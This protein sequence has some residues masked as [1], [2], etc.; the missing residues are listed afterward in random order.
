[1]SDHRQQR[2]YQQ[3]DQLVKRL[4]PNSN[5]AQGYIRAFWVGGVI[6]V[7]GQLISMAGESWFHMTEASAAMLTSI[8]LIFLGTTLT[9]IGVYD[10]IGRYAGAGSIVPITGFANSVA[11]PA[12]EFRREGLIMGVG[13]KLFV[14]AG[15]VLTYGIASSVVAGLIY[16][17]AGRLMG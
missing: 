5:Y 13:A 9:G 12:I 17:I 16:W 10:D 4:T 14:V 2:K 6:C 8:A 15:P 1:M 11:S 3:Y 7:I